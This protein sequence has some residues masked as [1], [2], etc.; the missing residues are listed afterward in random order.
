[1]LLEAL[2][3]I[4]ELQDSN[5]SMSQLK[6]HEPQ[7]PGRW[8]LHTGGTCC[9]GWSSGTTTPSSSSSSPS[10]L[11]TFIKLKKDLFIT[12]GDD[13]VQLIGR[14]IMRKVWILSEWNTW[15]QK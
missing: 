2:V 6:S 5:A 13:N 3:D 10:S 14:T 11:T 1:M 12:A 7:L 8:R 4:Q 15:A 9:K